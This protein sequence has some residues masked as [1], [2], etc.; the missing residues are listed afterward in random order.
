MIKKMT[1][2]N[3]EAHKESTVVFTQGV[4]VIIG[5][6]DS[7]KSALLRALYWVLEGKTA[8][9]DFRSWAGGDTEVKCLLDNGILRRGKGK[10]LNGYRINNDPPLTGFGRTI[11]EPVANLVNMNE[12][13]FQKQSD[14]YFMLQSPWTPGAVGS[15][16]NKITNLENIDAAINNIKKTIATEESEIKRAKED[17]NRLKSELKSYA[18]LDDAETDLNALEELYEKAGTRSIRCSALETLLDRLEDVETLCDEI[19]VEAQG[20]SEI[21]AL[22]KKATR[23]S[24]RQSSI[25]ELSKILDYIEDAD[26][27][28][29]S[30][31]R[32][33]ADLKSKFKEMM[34]EECPLCGN[35]V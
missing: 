17:T 8:G 32:E 19:D 35:E 22:I 33:I 20:E 14:P 23:A 27:E 3:F 11:P 28:I 18:D 1:V 31:T 6:S 25:R 10:A 4:N 29:Q 9:D 16:L 2:K 34:P 13:N 24:S 15:F 5:P 7:G 26:E 12:I 30:F 21:D